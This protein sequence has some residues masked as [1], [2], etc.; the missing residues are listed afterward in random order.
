MLLITQHHSCSDGWSVG[1]LLQEL[2]TLYTS[3]R[4][5][6]PDPLPPLPIQY[7]DYAAWQRWWLQGPS[8]QQQLDYWQGQLADAPTLLDLPLDRQRPIATGRHRRRSPLRT[9]CRADA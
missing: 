4:H 7:P 6:Q 2:S 8:R 1:V 9:G 5:G 3:C